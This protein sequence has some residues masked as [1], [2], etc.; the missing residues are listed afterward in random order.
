MMPS[1]TGLRIL[2]I[3]LVCREAKGTKARFLVRMSCPICLPTSYIR[4]ACQEARGAQA[5]LS[6]ISLINLHLQGICSGAPAIALTMLLV[7]KGLVRSGFRLQVNLD[8]L[9]HWLPSHHAVDRVILGILGTLV[10]L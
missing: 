1:G 7:T 2:Y 10:I 3:I 4:Q 8:M 9:Y 5:R 6:G